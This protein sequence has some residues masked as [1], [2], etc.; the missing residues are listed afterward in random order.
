MKSQYLGQHF[1]VFQF[2]TDIDRNVLGAALFFVAEEIF[3]PKKEILSKFKVETYTHEYIIEVPD[4]KKKSLSMVFCVPDFCLVLIL[5]MV[6]F[7]CSYI[8]K[9]ILYIDRL[10]VNAYHTCQ[11]KKKRL[12]NI[13]T[14]YENHFIYN[15]NLFLLKA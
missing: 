13:K 8:C 15:R 3:A 14:M 5:V 9:L 12:Y 7:P 6:N 10:K 2:L 1:T 11:F 4:T